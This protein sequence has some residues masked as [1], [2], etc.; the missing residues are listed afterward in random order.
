MKSFP[1]A[2]RPRIFDFSAPCF[3]AM[4]L[5]SCASQPH[6]NDYDPPAS[7]PGYFTAF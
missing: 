1:M 3:A 6:P 4:L 2:K 5:T 7:S